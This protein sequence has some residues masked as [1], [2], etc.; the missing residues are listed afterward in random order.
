MLRNF[1]ISLINY[2]FNN[3]LFINLKTT[4]FKNLEYNYDFSNISFEDTS[5]LN[6]ILL[7]NKYFKKNY[8]ELTN[9]Q[10][11][12]F[13]WLFN[14]K[15]IGGSEIINL[16]KKHIFVWSKKKYSLNSFVWKDDLVAKRLINLIYAYD[17]YAVSATKNERYLL[18]KII[19][20][21][22]FVL[23]TQEN[24]VLKKNNSRIEISKALFLFESIHKISTKK[25]IENI[26][27]KVDRHVNEN[28]MHNSMNPSVHIEYLN[29][30]FEIK[31]MF[32]FF[33]FEIP[34]IIELK[35]NEMSMVLKNLFHKDNTIAFFN[36]SNDAN[37]ESM[38]K[39]NK[40]IIDVKPKNL[41]NIKNGIAI[42]E[43]KK[44][45]IFFDT[46]KPTSRLINDNLHAST[47]SFEFSYDK[48]KIITNCGSMEK[49]IGKK[50]EFLRYSAA[51]STI[52]LNNTNISELVE[53]KSY[54]RIPKTILI[55]CYENE[56]DIIWTASHDGY[57]D[58]FKKV[59][60]RKLIISK[61]KAQIFGEDNIISTKINKSK[62][63]YDIRFHLSPIC[64]CLLTNNQKAVL[65][66]T[67][68]SQSWVFESESK[69]TLQDS[70][71]IK[72]GKRVNKTKQIVLSGYAT[73][74]KKTEKWQL[75]KI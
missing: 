58:N 37:Y 14:A 11:H 30:L 25:T 68:Q 1:I 18:S 17:Y 64:S 32:L 15:K 33:K 39:L 12:T 71:Y 22:Y 24:I 28:G 69:L 44:L 51:H 16:A 45:K 72:D 23:K 48:E 42:F 26:I 55:D 31:N 56:N 60:K 4:K 57:Q 35:I 59:I 63:N 27:F 9:F 5:A 20:K 43:S 19:H 21:H 53:N 38:S 50:P 10:Y 6:K 47:L 41:S 7:S 49:R 74:N 75:Y 8:R 65:I 67:N 40:K 73:Q 2:F 36:G 62:Q 34:K 29:H 61:T 46:V 13:N 52:I 66:K 70:I 3:N 54:K